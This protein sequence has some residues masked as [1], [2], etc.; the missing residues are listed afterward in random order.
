[1]ENPHEGNPDREPGGKPVNGAAERGEPEHR[2]Y[3]NE[4]DKTKGRLAFTWKCHN[5]NTTRR[6]GQSDKDGV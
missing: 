2:K 5:A 3:K 4:H 1:M 6:N